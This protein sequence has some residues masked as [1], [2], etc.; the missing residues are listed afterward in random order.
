MF[1]RKLRYRIDGAFEPFCYIIKD[2]ET[3]RV[4]IGSRTLYS[5]IKTK[6]TDLGN[7]YFT[8]S[9]VVR[10]LW[11][12][13]NDRFSIIC[14]IRCESNVSA[15]ETE[16]NLINLLN[17]VNS[18]NFYNMANGSPNF[19]TSGYTYSYES[20]QKMSNS[21]KK[22]FKNMSDEEKLKFSMKQRKAQYKRLKSFSPERRQ[23]IIN[24]AAESNKE[25]WKNA[26]TEYIEDFSKRISKIKKEQWKRKDK[27][28]KEDHIKNARDGLKNYYE[29]LSTEEKNELS[30]KGKETWKNMSD[31]MKKES[32]KKISEKAKNRQKKLCPYCDRRIDPGNFKKYHGDNCKKK[33]DS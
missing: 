25:F 27:K 13:Q 2:N 7:S 8:S 20:K 31:E 16:Y 24:K 10:E 5:T 18:E 29:N 28:S 6:E 19:S 15:L 30:R 33:N 9:K 17:A 21:R 11:T 26:S 32:A 1:N 4:Y 23:E 14:I 12:K 22:Y 3:N